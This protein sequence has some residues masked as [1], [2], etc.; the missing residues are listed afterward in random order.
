MGAECRWGKAGSNV[1]GENV[2]GRDKVTRGSTIFQ[3]E[4]VGGLGAMGGDV[5]LDGRV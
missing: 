2:M 3:R 4:A 5:C 1:G